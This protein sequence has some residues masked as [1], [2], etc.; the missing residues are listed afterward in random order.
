MFKSAFT[1][2]G[3]DSP[4]SGDSTNAKKPQAFQTKK[5]QLFNSQVT[6]VLYLKIITKNLTALSEA[7]IKEAVCFQLWKLDA[8]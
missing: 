8:H 6:V 2:S 7:F 1:Y 4:K 5:T 3:P